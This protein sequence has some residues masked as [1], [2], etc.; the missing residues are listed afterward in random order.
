MLTETKERLAASKYPPDA[1][2]YALTGRWKVRMRLCHLSF[3]VA[4]LGSLFLSLTDSFAAGADTTA[5]EQVIR[6]QMKMGIVGTRV[7]AWLAAGGT[8]QQVEALGQDVG[9]YL[10]SGELAKAET[11]MDSLFN[12]IVGAPASSEAAKIAA[13]ATRMVG[14]HYPIDRWRAAGGDPDKVAQLWATLG[15]S[16][17]SGSLT[18]VETQIDRIEAFV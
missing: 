8:P 9:T 12:I 10:A 7:Q 1:L 17:L 14:L 2:G 11:S 5:A 4:L 15:G 6:I 13:L 18:D 16:L 3:L